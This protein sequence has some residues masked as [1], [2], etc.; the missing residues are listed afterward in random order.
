[1][2]LDYTPLLVFVSLALYRFARLY[3]PNSR[4][5]YD[6]LRLKV[7]SRVALAF[8]NVKMAEALIDDILE[9]VAI[10]PQV[11]FFVFHCIK[12]LIIFGVLY[13]GVFNP[14]RLFRFGSKGV[15]LNIS[16]EELVELG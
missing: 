2:T 6:K 7:L 15:K 5:L 16:K 14:I 10:T 1:M 9:P 4:Y 8:G 3:F 11:L 13:A 12:V